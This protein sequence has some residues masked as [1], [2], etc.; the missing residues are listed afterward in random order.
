MFKVGDEV[1]CLSPSMNGYYDSKLYHVYYVDFISRGEYFYGYDIKDSPVGR[2]S[3]LLEYKH[4]IPFT[5]YRKR[6]L[7]RICS[8]LETR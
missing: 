5:E 1:V 8:K 7:E 6:K 2:I 3:T 4:F